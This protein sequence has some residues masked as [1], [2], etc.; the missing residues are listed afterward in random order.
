MLGSRVF[1]IANIAYVT[2]RVRARRKTLL[3]REVYQK[4]LLMQPSEISIYLSERGYA[5]EIDALSGRYFGTE[6]LEQATQAR[7][8]RVSR[9]VRHWCTGPLRA[10]VE[11]FL[12]RYD[13][14]NL[15]T[16][17]RGKVAGLSQETIDASLVAAGIIDDRQLDRWLAADDLQDILQDVPA[18]FMSQ[19]ADQYADALLVGADLARFEDTLDLAY[20]RHWHQVAETAGAQAGS[21]TR[22]V[23]YE[24][25]ILNL[26]TILRFCK[27]TGSAIDADSI[28]IPG[29]KELPLGRL[30][31]LLRIDDPRTLFNEL[32]DV[33]LVTELQ[34]DFERYLTDGDLSDLT[35][36]LRR[37]GLGRTRRFANAFPLSSLPVLE[38]LLR[39]RAEAENIRWI[40]I[41]K[42]AGIT[43]EVIRNGLVVA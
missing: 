14:S 7:M 25:D 6:L 23:G 28:L 20:W 31:S 17:I 41:G 12:G 4:L 29:G 38:F 19:V 1:G 5:T 21:L 37:V 18:G 11:G 30:R 39:V 35:V 22:F 27:T 40:A 33:P 26:E 16:V 34:A 32:Q 36:A 10:Q 24:I 2:A 13:A 43:D 15:K 8:A 9:E 3:D 42:A